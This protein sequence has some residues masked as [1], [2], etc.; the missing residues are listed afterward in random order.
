MLKK[1][2][3]E[4]MVGVMTLLRPKETFQHDQ[5]RT[6]EEDFAY[7][8]VIAQYVMLDKEASCRESYELGKSNRGK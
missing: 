2:I 5:E 8:R 1:E 6:L 7:L 4:N 3:H